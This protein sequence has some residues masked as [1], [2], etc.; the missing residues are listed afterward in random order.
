MAKHIETM[1]S[2]QIFHF[3]RKH[4]GRS[5][6]YAI[7]GKKN[8]RTVD[9]W[10]EDPRYTDKPD[11]ASDPILW[12]KNLLDTLD[13]H[14][15]THVV[16]AA[17]SFFKTGTSLEDEYAPVVDDLLPT[18]DAE[19]L[20]DFHAVARFQEAIDRGADC[21]EVDALKQAAIEE[22]E[23]TFAKYQEICKGI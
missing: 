19:K 2:W 10:C 16:R 23:R 5:V 11:S 12:V 3:T 6:L 13:D 22:V 20:A 9:Y 21:Q 4:L 15:Y 17:I 14:G 7:F 18:M 1:K 8:A